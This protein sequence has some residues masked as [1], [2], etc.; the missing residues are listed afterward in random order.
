MEA[1]EHVFLF[2]PFL[3]ATLFVA[4]LV[5]DERI[6][7]EASLKR[8]LG[9]LAGIIV[10]LGTFAAISGIIISGAVR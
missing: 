7:T 6:E 9:W 1:K 4:I 5:L 2:L 3:A 8:A 10:V